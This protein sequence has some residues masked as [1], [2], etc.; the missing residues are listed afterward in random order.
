MRL[1]VNNAKLE[2]RSDF[3]TTVDPNY[4]WTP[5]GVKKETL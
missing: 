3:T 5:N 2:G 4:E 1:R